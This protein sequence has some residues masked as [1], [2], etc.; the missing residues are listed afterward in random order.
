MD[1]YELNPHFRLRS[2]SIL[3]KGALSTP[4]ALYDYELMYVEK[5]SFTLVYDNKPF[6]CKKGDILLISPGITHYFI[7]EKEVSLPFIHFDAIKKAN[8]REIPVSFKDIPDMTEE[9]KTW[10]HKRYFPK[11]DG[12]PFLKCGNMERFLK[13]F[14]K[15]TYP[16]Y[17]AMLVRKAWLTELLAVLMH[18]NFLQFIRN[19]DEPSIEYQVKNYIDS[20]GC[21]NMTLQDFA[22]FFSYNKFYMI[23]KFKSTFGIG[24]MEYRNKVRLEK[25]NDLLLRFTLSNTA[26]LLG[27]TSVYSFSRAYK[28]YFGKAPKSSIT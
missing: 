23:R 6:F 10:I 14:N 28:E 12:E 25:S 20:N 24:I 9:E 16:T 26:K 13:L 1:I 3:N 21:Y 2:R 5:G 18:F 27:Y 15:L 8:S 11:Y 22:D 19:N 17:R 4:R 7:I